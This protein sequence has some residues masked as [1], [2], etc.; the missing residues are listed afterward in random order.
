MNQGGEK[1]PTYKTDGILTGSYL[2]KGLPSEHVIKG[3]TEVTWKR[4]RVFKQLLVDL[5]E[6]KGYCTLKEEALCGEL[7]WK[8][9]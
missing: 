7:L 3:K 4:G 5:K 9:L 8:T 6:T 2:A 1:Y